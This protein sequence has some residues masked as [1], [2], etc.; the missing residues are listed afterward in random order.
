MKAR[1]LFLSTLLAVSVLAAG[2]GSASY[3]T[4]ETA[5]AAGSYNEA[6]QEVADYEAAEVEDSLESGTLTGTAL[7]E[8]VQTGRKLIRTFDM[9][10]ETREFDDVLEGI[11]NKVA[12]LGGYIESSSLDSGSE[13]YSRYNRHIDLTVR[14]PSEKIDQFVENVKESANVTYVSEYTD[15]ITLK[16]VDTES[17]KLALETER[18]RL[19]DLLEKAETVED[20]ITI[21]SRLSEVR[22]DLESYTSQLRTFDNQVDYST[23]TLNIREVD[24]EVKAEPKGLWEEIKERFEESLYDLGQGVRGFVIWFLGSLPYLICIVLAAGIVLWGT[25][26]IRRRRKEKKTEPKE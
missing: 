16:Y 19:M 13:Y 25:R 24:R 20:I 10:I 5:V 12:E 21:E 4:A 23:V 15:D 11:K 9:N 1:N 26:K 2:C 7:G 17:R 22:Y 3:D 6:K 8:N 18:D 14:V